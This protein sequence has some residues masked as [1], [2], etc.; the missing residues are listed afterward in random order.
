MAVVFYQTQRVV[1]NMFFKTYT[2]IYNMQ[3]NT[4]ASPEENI[5]LIKRSGKHL[6]I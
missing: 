4:F 6:L 2:R 5:I 3:S 1:L